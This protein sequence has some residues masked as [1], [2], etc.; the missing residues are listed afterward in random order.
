MREMQLPNGL[1]SHHISQPMVRNQICFNGNIIRTAPDRMT[2]FIRKDADLATRQ[3]RE[4][5]GQNAG[6]HVS[7]NINPS[8][9]NVSQVITEAY[10]EWGRQVVASI[11]NYFDYERCGISSRSAHESNV[12]FHNA[13]GLAQTIIT[14]SSHYLAERQNS[15]K[16]IYVSLD[17]LITSSDFG[18]AHIPRAS[19]AE[20]GFSREFTLE[21]EQKGYVG[22]P[23]KGP[24]EQQLSKLKDICKQERAGRK[25][26]VGLVLLEDNIRH[27]KMPLWIV[28]RM[29]E[30]GVLGEAKVVAIATCFS[31]ASKEEREKLVVDGKVMPLIVGYEYEGGACEHITT[32]DHLFDGLVVKTGSFFGRLPSF[33]LPDRKMCDLFKIKA[34]SVRSFRQ[35]V[36]DANIQFCETLKTRLGETPSLSS[37]LSG[38]VLANI[39]NISQSSSMAVVLEKYRPRRVPLSLVKG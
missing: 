7:V 36:I 21:G 28:E 22:R 17:D 33:M 10:A 23:G 27:A 26:K 34:V 18:K 39:C 15:R 1:L 12:H 32:R 31:L 19:F 4:A 9:Q 6:K 30:R 14:R 38:P 35:E 29:K 25:K 24:L 20:I 2:F 37:F 11:V 5:Y 13:S 3:M 8:R 16:I